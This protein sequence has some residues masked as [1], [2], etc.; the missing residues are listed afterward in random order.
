LE[1]YVSITRHFRDDGTEPRSWL[2]RRMMRSSGVGAP[3]D[4]DALLAVGA[5]L[6]LVLV[7]PT[8]TGK[9]TELRHQASKLRR[10]GRCAVYADATAIVDGGLDGGLDGDDRAEYERW[11]RLPDHLVLFVDAIDELHLQK[12]QLQDLL[13]RLTRDIDIASRKVRF[14]LSSRT[15]TWTDFS[16]QRL[17][18][19][20]RL[21]GDDKPRVVTFEP[22]DDDALRQLARAA[23]VT[24]IDAF[25]RAFED[26][27]VGTL[28]ELRPE[29]VRYLA[30]M[31]MEARRFGRWS[32][33]LTSFVDASSHETEA[34]RAQSRL[35]TT[36]DARKGLRRIAA[37]MLLTKLPQI[38]VPIVAGV[39]TAI[40]SRRLFDDWTSA[41]ILEL[42]ENPLLV[43][44][45]KDLEAAQLP[46]GTLYHF[47][48]AQW[49]AD[50]V[51]AGQDVESI[52]DAL[53]VKV[54]D[55]TAYRIPAAHHAVVGWV[56]SEV[57]AFRRM[58]L[59][60]HPAVALYEGDTDKLTDGEIRTALQ[61]LC[62]QLAAGL[63]PW[64][65]PSPATA[66]KLARPGVEADVQRLLADYAQRA[67]AGDIGACT[68]VRH[69]LRL[70]AAGPFTS[71]LGD[72]TKLAL[73][74][75]LDAGVRSKAINVVAGT[76]TMLQRAVLR[77]LAPDTTP[78]IQSALL[79]AFVAEGMAGPELVQIICRGGDDGFSFALRAIA[80]RVAL[81][82]IDA[83]VTLLTG[84][85]ARAVIDAATGTAFDIA[86]V[87][88]GARLRRRTEPAPFLIDA[89]CAVE[90]H[91]VHN[92]QYL[93][94]TDR[95]KLTADVQSTTEFRR[96]L[97][98]ARIAAASEDPAMFSLMSNP[99][100]GGASP[101]DLDWLFAKHESG[102]GLWFV[103][104]AE[105]NRLSQSDRATVL[106]TASPEFRAEV[107]AIAA[108]EVARQRHDRARE[109]AR[110]RK[111]GRDRRANIR[112]IEPR[113]SAIESGD[114]LG[115]LIAAWQHVD[116]KV[117]TRGDLDLNRLRLQ[118]GDEYVEVFRRGFVTCWRK[119]DVPLP[120]PGSNQRLIRCA[121]GLTGVD[122]EAR[123]GLDFSTL[124]P[125][126]AD[127]AARYA[128]YEIN[129]L[130]FWFAALLR[131][132]PDAVQS[133]L[134][135][136]ISADWRCAVSTHGVLRFASRGAPEVADVLRAI[137]LDLLRQA[138]PANGETTHDAVG[139][140][141]NSQADTQSVASLALREMERTLAQVQDLPEW[142]RLAAHV[143][144][145]DSARWLLEKVTK[146]AVPEPVVLR[147]A[148]LLQHD[149][150]EGYGRVAA[151]ALMA[152]RSLG[153]WLKIILRAVRPEDDAR[154]DGVHY[155]DTREHAEHFRDKCL[156]RLAN[157]PSL[158]AHVVLAKLIADPSLKDHRE[159]FIR[160]AEQQKRCAADA[161]A[162]KWTEE[163]VLRFERGDEKQPRSLEELF[164][165]VARHLRHVGKL[166]ENDDFSYRDLFS[167][168]TAEREIQ[169]WT[170]SCL[171]ER[172][173]GLYSIE[174]ENVVANDKEVDITAFAPGIGHVP[175]E[176]KPLGAYSPLKLVRVVR[177]QLLGQY[178]LPPD[179]KL[180]ILLLVRRDRK[181]WTIDGKQT[182][183]FGTLQTWL[184]MRATEIASAMSKTVRVVV[185][186]LLSTSASGLDD[187]RNDGT[188]RRSAKRR[189]AN[190]NAP[191]GDKPAASNVR[192]ASMRSTRS[193]TR[194]HRLS[195][196]KK[197]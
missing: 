163:D 99:I 71:C 86:V 29:D 184:Q 124:S 74:P 23:G 178:M 56:A 49:L 46:D 96:A 48:A 73:H 175:I 179:R 132:H 141:L 144:P 34:G 53:L 36:L 173:R 42:F 37:A 108:R 139:A 195:P 133:V 177:D 172:A 33:L 137:A 61:P 15:G 13:R 168:D 93:S 170:A 16:T 109:A 44:K 157:N 3:L 6:P 31:W 197:K 41:K 70:A 153:D 39:A 82:D 88:L 192:D 7:A 160:M 187:K 180:G 51:H 62:A 60:E 81:A 20:A 4:W 78:G 75:K 194:G 196:R 121:V 55:E 154:H 32:D 167:K 12:R 130:P 90:R 143:V 19:F 188:A 147:L 100:F 101:D 79:E 189:G 91:A 76:G 114:E 136:A 115:A 152:P 185:I 146:G 164:V 123:A 26:E 18:A 25:V 11:K 111:E 161:A 122:I 191:R 77:T 158:D 120:T 5:T 149:L 182:D 181:K 186:D 28:L 63:I 171:R 127:K 148:E 117:E 97:W 103:I 106:A 68:A 142:L 85:L 131:A 67:S 125:V 94:S 10:Q 66:R 155:L 116:D 83:A 50:R 98:D 140:I 58:L 138:P 110:K 105:W 169:Q 145:Q 190:G 118:V 57:P 183:D 87:L 27:E 1:T 21:Q 24:D 89:L 166:I 134:R 65:W 9:S 119:Q 64:L 35:L 102:T 38:T 162:S 59:T 174:R 52:R 95:D 112:A 72:A 8:R 135:E 84:T 14:V 54:F 2:T 92:V 159:R 165:L 47:L 104:E 128:F 17:G 156:E 113:R 151:S 43:H 150:D 80:D 193:V 69:L 30:K 176:I 107:E 129:S 126:D 22:I 40:S 45:G